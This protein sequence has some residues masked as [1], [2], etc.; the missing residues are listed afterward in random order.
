[1][2][3]AIETVIDKLAVYRGA[4]TFGMKNNQLVK[5]S[6]QRQTVPQRQHFNNRRFKEKLKSLTGFIPFTVKFC[7]MDF[8]TLTGLPTLSGRR[9]T[10][11]SGCE[12]AD[13]VGVQHA[14]NLPVISIGG[15]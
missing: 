5:V 6:F 10:N 2:S 8:V 7:A 3:L 14:Q 9:E 15:F 4:F 12:A 13:R 11:L 1:M